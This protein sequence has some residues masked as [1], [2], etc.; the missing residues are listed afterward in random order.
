MN[1]AIEALA[2]DPKLSA[3]AATIESQKK[4]L[5]QVSK[6]TQYKPEYSWNYE[7]GSHLTLWEGKL[8]ADLAVFYMDT[9]DQQIS[10]FA[11]SGLGRITINAGKS[12]SYGAEASLRASLTN[13]LS[14]NASYGYTYATFTD[15]IVNEE[16]KDGNLTVKADYNGKYVPFVP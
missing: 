14:L 10:Q 13:E 8:W 9:R 7:L 16:D 1:S 12:R 2:A 15:Y 5:P 11:A 3:M 4:E 6:A